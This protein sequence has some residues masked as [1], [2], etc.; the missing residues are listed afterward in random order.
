[1]YDGLR[2]VFATIEQNVATGDTSANRYTLRGTQADSGRGYEVQGL[3]MIRVRDGKLV[4][5]WAIV[6]GAAM[7]E[8]LALDYGRPAG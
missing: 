4:E 5:H 3:D 7:H 8:Q 1:M 6:D 2:D